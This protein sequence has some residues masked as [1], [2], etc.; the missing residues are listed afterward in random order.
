[1]S[2]SEPADGCYDLAFQGAYSLGEGAQVAL[3]DYALAVTRAAT[4]EALRASDDPGR[5]TG[6]HVCRLGATLTRVALT[7]IED[8]ARDMATRTGASARLGWS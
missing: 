3:E 2:V 7:D 5:V 4:A 6:I 1:M 8:F